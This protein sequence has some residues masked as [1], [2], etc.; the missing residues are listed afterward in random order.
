MKILFIF[1]PLGYAGKKVASMS[2]VPPVLE[3]LAGLTTKYRPDWDIRIMN[4]NREDLNVE[5]IDAGMVGI[6]VLTHQARWAYEV[7]DKLRERGIKVI[8]GG[9][10]PAF[11]AQEAKAHADSVVVGEAEG[12]IE[13]LLKDVEDGTLKPFYKGGLVPLTGL[14]HPRRDLL[15]GYTFRAFST[16]RGC[17]YSCKF[18]VTPQLYGRRVRYRP[19]DDVIE[20]IS[21]FKSRYWFSTDA[22]IWGPD[23]DRYIELFKE[24]ARSLP[25]LN[26][27]G[28]ANLSPVEHP[29][30]EELLKWA[31]RSGLM[32]VGIGL[33]SLSVENLHSYRN[34]P[35][36]GKDSEEAIRIIRDNGIDVV[37]FLMLGGMGDDMDA[38]KKVLEF[39]DRLKVSAHPV[40][41]V[42]YPGTDI[43][44][45]WEGRLLY[46]DNWDMYDGLHMLVRQN[47]TTPE[48]HNRA[49]MDLWT[50]LFTI[51]R[52]VKR[53]VRISWKGF[54][55]AHFASA[56]F[57]LAIRDAFKQY[58]VEE[59]AGVIDDVKERTADGRHTGDAQ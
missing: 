17:P 33:E 53:I 12:V 57:Q 42:P 41:I 4:A 32:Q 14:P 29:R 19:I 18:C 44:A 34:L 6:S 36:I 45:E 43:R 11:M 10:H 51:P 16:A 59:T 52:I 31:R 7:S 35:K 1:P 26:W 13:E 48:E 2:L 8:L 38:Y 37:V 56:M 25:K 54:P 47:G 30:G 50:E 24:M 23:V 55:S 9:P 39:C 5:E 21:S 28:E 27:Y 58:I 22:D 46:G 3:Y 20:D 40:M 49:L 15:N